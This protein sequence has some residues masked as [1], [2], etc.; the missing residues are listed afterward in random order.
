MIREHIGAPSND[1]CVS[2]ASAWKIATKTRLGKWP[3]AASL[4]SMFP[5]VIEANGFGS[6][7]ITVHHAIHAG[8]LLIAHADPF[9]RMLAA[10]AEL[11]GM[12]LV[13]AD[14]AFAQF[15]VPILW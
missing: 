4:A 3:E 8:A 2:A 15:N 6:L 9:D 13:T 11:E 5:G 1:V 10:Q 7:A 14:S 12:A